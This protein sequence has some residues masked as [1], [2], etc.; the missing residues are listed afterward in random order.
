MAEREKCCDLTFYVDVSNHRPA[1]KAENLLLSLPISSLFSNCI[2]LSERDLSVWSGVGGT[3]SVPSGKP[4]SSY[5]LRCMGWGVAQCHPNV[6]GRWGV[7][8]H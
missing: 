8:L 7:R 2:V 1:I 5:S 4:P 6:T 3:S